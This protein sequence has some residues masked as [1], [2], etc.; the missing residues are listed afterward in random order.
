VSTE[1]PVVAAFDFDGTL[2]HSDSVIPFLRR[3]TGTPHLVAGC[4]LRAHRL[5]PAV[6]RRDRDGVRAVATRVAFTGVDAT[7][8]DRHAAEFGQQVV[9]SGLRDD[10]VAR[11]RWHLDEGHQVVIVSAS[12]EQYVQVVADHFS[13]HGVC[14]TQLERT[15]DTFTGRLHGENCRGPEKV[16]RLDA[17]LGERGL[18]RDRITL[19][20]YGDSN[21]DNELLAAADHPIWVRD[22]LASVAATL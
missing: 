9:A 1:R 14:A 15:G 4:L 10:T 8:V 2:T 20:A 5:V 7:V 22:P 21:G 6:S 18:S 17:W 19:W 16:R 11:L 13:I 3:V 12:Y